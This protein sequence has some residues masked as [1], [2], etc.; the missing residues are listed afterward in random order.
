MPQTVFIAQYGH[1]FN[2]ENDDGPETL[3]D[4]AAPSFCGVYQE[5]GKAQLE[6][7]LEYIQTEY[8]EVMRDD[9]PKPQFRLEAGAWEPASYEGAVHIRQITYELFD[10]ARFTHDFREGTDT[11]GVLVAVLIVREASVL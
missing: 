3:A 7:I 10:D 8:R 6:S 5:F 4:Y 2:F 9:V 1:L 11:F